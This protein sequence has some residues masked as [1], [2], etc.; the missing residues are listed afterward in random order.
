MRRSILALLAFLA[1]AVPVEAATLRGT[2]RDSATGKPVAQARVELLEAAGTRVV[3]TDDGGSFAIE[4][5]A[6]GPVT[7]AVSHP[8]YQVTRLELSTSAR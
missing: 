6:T 8:G 2:V 1:A 5:L 4:I 7:L 3:T